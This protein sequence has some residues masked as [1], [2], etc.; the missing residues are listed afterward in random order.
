MLSH[1]KQAGD[2]RAECV[3]SGK[4]FVSQDPVQCHIPHCRLDQH[5]AGACQNLLWD[6]QSFLIAWHNRKQTF[7]KK[8]CYLNFTKKN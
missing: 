8:N 6:F 3:C 5:Q 4:V 2:L 1:V 7:C